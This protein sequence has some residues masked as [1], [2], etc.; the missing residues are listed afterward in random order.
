MNGVLTDGINLKSTAPAL[1][2][3]IFTKASGTTS[4]VLWSKVRKHTTRNIV[5]TPI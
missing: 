3:A 2:Y 1:S 4:T 5:K